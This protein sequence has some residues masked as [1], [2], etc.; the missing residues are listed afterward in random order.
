MASQEHA[1]T[2]SS[3]KSGEFQSKLSN[4]PAAG[5][6]Q[7]CSRFEYCCT[8]EFL[9]S[10]ALAGDCHI[11]LGRTAAAGHM[12]QA[13]VAAVAAEPQTPADTRAV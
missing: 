6:A 9:G 1:M 2:A 12:A 5:A 4:I 8:A 3:Q 7:S 10:L 11:L 13:A